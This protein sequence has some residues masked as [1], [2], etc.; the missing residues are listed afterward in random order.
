MLPLVIE[1][2][3][4]YMLVVL[5]ILARYVSRWLLLGSIK[6]FQIGDGV[7]LV[8][9][10]F[11]S[12][13]VPVMNIISNL[14]SN[15]ILPK[16]IPLLTPSSIND[17][18]RGSQLTVVVEQSMIVTIWGCKV[19]LL[20]LYSKLTVGLTYRNMVKL[21]GAY[22]LLSFIA[23]EILYF[24]VWCRPFTQMWAV[25]VDN[26]Q[27]SAAI[28]HLATNAFFNISS[29]AMMLC[30][31]LPIL[32]NSQ[33][34]R[35]KKVILCTL[36][37][38]GGFVIICAILNKF[39]SFNDPFSPMWTYWYIREASTALLVA[40]LPMCWTLMRRLFNLRSFMNNS[41]EHESNTS[42]Q[43]PIPLANLEPNAVTGNR[44]KGWWE[45]GT[46]GRLYRTKSG[47]HIIGS[48]GMNLNHDIDRYRK[49]LS[50]R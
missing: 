6:R 14:D 9:L 15:L 46:A 35:T 50:L 44:D 12:V 43:A 37:S 25:P 2:W 47:E 26:I 13:L 48:P 18:I 16:D 49:Q 33:L 8:V 3:I 39:Y 7:M 32:I 40:N 17:R 42:H 5:V 29:D 11:Y 21:V 30:I 27:C 28:N 38:L 20:L 22:V 31:P 36:F 24:A 10:G 45:G 34:P 19:C 1:S 41:S 23:M 4:W